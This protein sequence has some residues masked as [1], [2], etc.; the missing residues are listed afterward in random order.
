M[1]L[2]GLALLVSSSTLLAGCAISPLSAYK[3][4]VR[5]EK[6]ALLGQK[7][8]RDPVGFLQYA[9]EKEADPELQGKYYNVLGDALKRRGKVKKAYA[10]YETGAVK[11]NES[12]GNEI[13][14]A[15][16]AGNYQPKKLTQIASAVYVPRAKG[17]KGDGAALFLADL[18][19]SGQLA[20]KQ[21]HSSTYWLQKAAAGGSVR[22]FRLLAED[23]ARRG[24]VRAAA[25]YYQKIDN[26]PP[27]VRA[28]SEA[29]KNFLGKDGELNRELG[30]SWLIYA[31]SIAPTDTAALAAKLF[32]ATE[33]KYYADE[34]RRVAAA[35]GIDD[36]RIGNKSKGHG[37]GGAAANSV[38][39]AAYAASP[40]DDVKKKVLAEL[41][42]KADRGDGFAAYSLARIL[43]TDGGFGNYKPG[44]YYVAALEKN[45]LEAMTRVGK[46]IA[47]LEPDSPLAVRILKAMNGLA[48]KGNPEALKTLGALY[49]VG[50]PVAI[51]YDKGV[52]FL[53]KAA[54]G[55]DDD[56]SYRLGVL[57]IQNSKGP[58]DIVAGKAYLEKA[59][60]KGNTAANRFLT[61]Y[62]KANP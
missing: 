53:K 32:R 27:K 54:D 22:A 6:I 51:D 34:L 33:G 46:T 52:G 3:E 15:H 43:E 8:G 36:L 49:I 30:I 56:A 48:S 7:P 62:I 21:F 41:I 37:G 40:N 14:K 57:T 17:P 29:K 55:G 25:A 47:V 60:K 44:P 12:A 38:L 19:G 2:V 4:G 5:E 13:Y 58:S 24:R 26:A 16:V 45:N 11:G 9:A 35:G 42:S 18:V 61:E 31:E 59:S 1:R 23:E 10:A 50:G 28:L 39:T 20:G